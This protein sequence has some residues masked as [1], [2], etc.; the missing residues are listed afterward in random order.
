MHAQSLQLC[1]TLCNSV[2][3]SPPGSSVHGKTIGVDCHALLRG[4]FLTQGS[5]PCLLSLLHWQAGSLP[6]APPGKPTKQCSSDQNQ[7]CTVRICYLIQLNIEG[8]PIF[9]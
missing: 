2:D 3:Y 9:I 6:L 5:D 7:A 4:L 1:Q 8:Q